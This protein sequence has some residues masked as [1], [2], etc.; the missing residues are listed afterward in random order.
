MFDIYKGDDFERAFR[1]YHIGTHVSSQ[2][3]VV[4]RVSVAWC[5]SSSLLQV[6]ASRYEAS[7]ES[8]A[9]RSLKL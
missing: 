4:R 7:L 3:C 8:I 6:V 5:Q 1:P 2:S 9:E